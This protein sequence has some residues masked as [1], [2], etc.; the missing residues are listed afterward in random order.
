MKQER[1]KLYKSGMFFTYIFLAATILSIILQIISS[2]REG[3]NIWIAFMSPTTIPLYI[4]GTLWYLS[5]IYSRFSLFQPL[6]MLGVF[7]VN[8]YNSRPGYRDWAGTFTT[9]FFVCAVIMLYI[10]GFLEK[11]RVLKIISLI[12][13]YYATI[14]IG[15]A[16]SHEGFE[17]VFGSVFFITAFIAFLYVVFSDQVTVYLRYEKPSLSLSAY[18]L[19][20]LEA[21]YARDIVAGKNFKEIALDF[22]V[23]ES[24]VRNTTARIYKKLSVVDKSSLAALLAS[25][26]L[27]D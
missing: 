24:T 8:S 25:H 19:T 20:A 17:Y 5:T 3:K 26:S 27:V 15:I 7:F 6:V 10:G 11:R 14:A 21:K 2:N 12:V 23:S 4:I 16:N 1:H 13:F 22:K 9:G 18:G